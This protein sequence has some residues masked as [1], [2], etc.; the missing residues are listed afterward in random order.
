MALDASKGNFDHHQLNSD[1]CVC[2]LSL[3]LQELGYYQ[4][5]L[6]I[7]PWLGLTEVQDTH[8]VKVASESLRVSTDAFMAML[9][10]VEAALM[11]LFSTVKVLHPG[12]VLYKQME[13]IGTV[14]TRQLHL[15]CLDLDTFKRQSVVLTADDKRMLKSSMPHDMRRDARRI[16]GFLRSG[17]IDHD[18]LALLDASSSSPRWVLYAPLRSKVSLLKSRAPAIK[19]KRTLDAAGTVAITSDLSSDDDLRAVLVS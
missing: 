12:G 5:A 15:F 8:G 16:T 1:A 14:L 4:A 17:Q 6:A 9:S 19:I 13:L 7:W 10:P 11:Q 18:V 2:A 3:V